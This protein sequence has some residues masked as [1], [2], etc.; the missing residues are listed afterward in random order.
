MKQLVG[1]EWPGNVRQLE[2]SVEMA[3][4]L[5]GDRELL[6]VTDFFRSWIGS[7]RTTGSLQHR[8]PGGRG[9]FQHP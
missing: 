5:S 9:E 8:H 2:N 4:A 1:F 6:A 7:R 3:V